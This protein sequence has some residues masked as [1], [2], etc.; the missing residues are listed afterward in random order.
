MLSM[1]HVMSAGFLVF[2]IPG[3]STKSSQF[4]LEIGYACVWL[5]PDSESVC[6]AE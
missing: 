3:D 4:L 1:S 2:L 6:V 5:V